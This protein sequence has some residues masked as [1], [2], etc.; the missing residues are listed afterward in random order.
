MQSS[1]CTCLSLDHSL[2]NSCAIWTIRGMYCWHAFGVNADASIL[3]DCVCCA[4]VVA[5]MAF[6]PK[7]D[8]TVY[9]QWT[10]KHNRSARSCQQKPAVPGSFALNSVALRSTSSC[11]AFISAFMESR[12]ATWIT[13]SPRVQAL[14]ATIKLWHKMLWMGPRV[15]SRQVPSLW[16]TYKCCL[17]S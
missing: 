12:S 6:L 14:L 7:M 13:C 2:H 9:I 3:R 4:P 17:T 15:L 16:F 11:S 8:L 1:P 5:M 10:V